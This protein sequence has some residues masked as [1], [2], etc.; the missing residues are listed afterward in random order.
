M[1]GRRGVDALFTEVRMHAQTC[2]AWTQGWYMETGGREAGPMLRG[3]WGLSPG[4]SPQ[5]GSCTLTVILHLVAWVAWSGRAVTSRLAAVRVAAA[6]PLL[7]L[8]ALLSQTRLR[9]SL[10]ST[11][12]TLENPASRALEYPGRAPRLWGG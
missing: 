4:L 8:C 1:A 7:Q 2:L 9:L 5:G 11:P 10:T 3:V 12:R 6:G